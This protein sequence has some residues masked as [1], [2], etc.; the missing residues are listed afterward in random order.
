[1]AW[2]KLRIVCEELNFFWEEKDLKKLAVMWNEGK[3]PTQMAAYLDREDPD[4][5][6]LALLQLARDGKI[7]SREGGL[8]GMTLR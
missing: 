7:S 1:M 3:G 2:Q 6:L 8:S 5:I 4:E